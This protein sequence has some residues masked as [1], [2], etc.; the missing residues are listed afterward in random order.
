NSFSHDARFDHAF[1]GDLG[2]LAD[3]VGLENLVGHGMTGGVEVLAAT[4]RMDPQLV[5]DAAR[6]VTEEHVLAPLRVGARLG[7]ERARNMGLALG[8]ELLFGALCAAVGAKYVQ[9]AD[10]LSEPRRQRRAR[11]SMRRCGSGRWRT[12]WPA[13]AFPRVPGWQRRRDRNPGWP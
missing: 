13:G 4:R 11:Q 5:V 3:L 2:F 1:G 9:H 6:V 8:A 7:I 10:L 12:A